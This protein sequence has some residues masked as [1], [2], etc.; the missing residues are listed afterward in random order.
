MHYYFHFTELK[1]WGLEKFCN[2]LKKPNQQVEKLGFKVSYSVLKSH[3]P[4]TKTYT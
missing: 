1:N 2:L 4:Y 3:A